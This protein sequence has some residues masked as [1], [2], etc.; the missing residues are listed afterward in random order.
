MDPFTPLKDALGSTFALVD[1][2]GNLVTA[3]AYDPFGNTTVSGAAQTNSSTRGVRM[4]ATDS[5][6]IE[7]A[8]TR[9]LTGAIHQSGPTGVFG[10]RSKF[11][12]IRWKQPNQLYGSVRA[13]SHSNRS[14]D[15]DTLRG[16]TSSGSS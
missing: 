8:I 3:Y 2:S 10:K 7:R 11:L 4:K 12:R 14:Y 13:T 1:A 5:I 15:N 9:R 16:R 6:F